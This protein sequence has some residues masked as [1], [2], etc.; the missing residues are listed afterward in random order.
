MLAVVAFSAVFALPVLLSGKKGPALVK[1][2]IE[3]QGD[4]LEI[5]AEIFRP[6]EGKWPLVM[7]NKGGII[8]NR[9]NMFFSDELNF[10]NGK[11]EEIS[12]QG[13]VVAVCQYRGFWAEVDS[14][15]KA[16]LWEAMDDLEACLD[17]VK[18]Q[19]YV[20]PDKVGMVGGDLG[21]TLTYLLCQKRDDI[22]AAAVFDAPVDFLDP[23]GAFRSN[24]LLSRQMRDDLASRMGGT[25]EDKPELYR[26]ISPYYDMK[27]I[28]T[29][30]LIIHA[31]EDHLI[32]LRQGE[33]A[34]QALLDAG[35]P[36]QFLIAPKAN[37]YLFF[38]PAERGA[39]KMA[40]QEVYRFLEKNLK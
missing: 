40:W 36:F 10:V 5:P 16:G 14:N 23:Q 38:T 6:E 21:G 7:L 18:Q 19:P 26:P 30:V 25:I 32:P 8:R 2:R 39:A 1:S 28:Q 12:R 13:Y 33:L 35:K 31:Q 34:R 27:N 11:A 4:G 24:N 29:P 37:Q 9:R 15:E 22:N 3:C 20:L 17:K